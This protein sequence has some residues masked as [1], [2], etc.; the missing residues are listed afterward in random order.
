LYNKYTIFILFVNTFGHFREQKGDEALFKAGIYL[1]QAILGFRRI[2]EDKIKFLAG[3]FLT[4]SAILQT[5]FF[6]ALPNF[7]DFA[8]IENTPPIGLTTITINILRFDL[9]LK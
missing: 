1:I 5:S 9:Y 2:A 4:I 7:T 8:V 6:S 3:I